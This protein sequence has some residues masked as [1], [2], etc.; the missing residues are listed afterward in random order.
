[1]HGLYDKK[2]LEITTREKFARDFVAQLDADITF[3]R[4]PR[5]ELISKRS[6]PV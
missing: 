4:Q 6:W 1:M 5:Q 2:Q 3:K